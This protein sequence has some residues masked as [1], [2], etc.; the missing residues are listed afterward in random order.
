MHEH[1]LQRFFKSL[2]EQPVFAWERFQMRDVLVIDHPPVP[3]GIQ[4]PG[5]AVAAFPTHGPEAMAVVRG[6]VAAGRGDPWRRASVLAVV[7]PP[8]QRKRLA[9][10]WLG[11]LD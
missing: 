5:R 11:T 8:S 7:W 3:G 4:P 10:P 1:P 6:Q 9:L 2:R